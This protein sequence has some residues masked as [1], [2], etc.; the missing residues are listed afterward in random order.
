MF[1]VYI[2]NQLSSI[3]IDKAS[4]VHLNNYDWPNEIYI[5]LPYYYTNLSLIKSINYTNN[6]TIFI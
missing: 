3:N 5:M 4:I 6:Y 1:L 2:Y